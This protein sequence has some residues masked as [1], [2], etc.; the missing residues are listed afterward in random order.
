MTESV[1]LVVWLP[2][3]NHTLGEYIVNGQ[4]PPLKKKKAFF[5]KGGGLSKIQITF[6][7]NDTFRKPFRDLGRRHFLAKKVF[8]HSCP[9][10]SSVASLQKF[11]RFFLFFS[12]FLW[13]LPMVVIKNLFFKSRQHRQSRPTENH[14]RTGFVLCKKVIWVSSNPLPPKKNGPFFFFGGG[15]SLRRFV[16]A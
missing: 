6:F 5:L 9:V 2:M 8:F 10:P 13:F 4:T 14:S 11:C 7:Y 1:R 15:G 16:A 12:L 3:L